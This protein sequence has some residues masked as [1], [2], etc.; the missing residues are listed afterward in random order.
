M[1]GG[2]NRPSILWPDFAD[3]SEAR[4]RVDL[5]AARVIVDPIRAAAEKASLMVSLV[6]SAPGSRA[7]AEQLAEFS[8]AT[9]A[10]EVL[11]KPE[12][13]EKIKAGHLKID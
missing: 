4:A 11:L 1:L 10:T 6:A 8:N 2:P 9:D 13:R 7:R 12:L 3:C 5:L